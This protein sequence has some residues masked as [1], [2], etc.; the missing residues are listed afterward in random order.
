MQR[1]PKSPFPQAQRKRLWALQDRQTDRPTN[2]LTRACVCTNTHTY[3][4]TLYH[5]KLPSWYSILITVAGELHLCPKFHSDAWNRSEGRLEVP[6]NLLGVNQVPQLT[7]VL[8]FFNPFLF[9][10]PVL[11]L[12]GTVRH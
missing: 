12:R 8:Q 7:Y 4:H 6:V 1:L 5:T 2:R 11:R 9:M 3:T 10:S